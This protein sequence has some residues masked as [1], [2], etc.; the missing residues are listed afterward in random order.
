MMGGW[1]KKGK[2]WMKR[3]KK[4]KKKGRSK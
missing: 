3:E 2:Q 4:E 1:I